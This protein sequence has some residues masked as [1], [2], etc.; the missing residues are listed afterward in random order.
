MNVELLNYNKHGESYW[1]S[2]SIVYIKNN[3]GGVCYL[4][5]IEKDITDLMQKN[6]RLK[7]TND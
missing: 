4:G 2:F 6:I 5:A 3:A 7:K 1:I